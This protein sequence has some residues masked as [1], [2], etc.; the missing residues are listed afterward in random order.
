MLGVIQ[1]EGVKMKYKVFTN[2]SFFYEVE[3]KDEEE[4]MA[5][6]HNEEIKPT[7]V[8]VVADEVRKDES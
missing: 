2:V 7:M 1:A 5:K 4:A 8:E 3:A 6:V